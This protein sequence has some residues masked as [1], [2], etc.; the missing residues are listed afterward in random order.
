MLKQVKQLQARE[1]TFE[2]EFKKKDNQIKSLQDSIKKFQERHQFKNSFD[3][4]QKFENGPAI[5]AT[6][7]EHEY[8]RLASSSID[9]TFKKLRSE[10]Q[11]LKDCLVNIYK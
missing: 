9:E 11:Y 8:S 10:N 6:N 3:V 4:V 5:Y 2:A 7:A 1:R